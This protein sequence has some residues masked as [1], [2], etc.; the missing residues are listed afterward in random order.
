MNYDFTPTIDKLKICYTLA[1]NSYLNILR[2]NPTE[3]FEHPEWGVQI[4][5]SARHSL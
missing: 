5:A 1:E 2:D 4:K 3:E